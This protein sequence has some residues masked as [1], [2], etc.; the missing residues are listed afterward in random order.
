MIGPAAFKMQRVPQE[1]N[2]CKQSINQDIGIIANGQMA[3]S[4]M[5]FVRD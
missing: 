1:R 3:V 4:A 2:S 5:A